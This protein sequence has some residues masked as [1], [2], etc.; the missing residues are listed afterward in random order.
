MQTRDEKIAQIETALRGR[1]FPLVPKVEIPGRENWLEWQHDTDRLSRALAAY[2][3]VG[4]CDLDD[5][6]AAAAIT[7]GSND[8]G[9]DALYFDRESNRLVFVQAKFKRN[10]AA[11]SQDENLKTING[12]RALQARR[13]NEFNAAFQDRLDTIEAGLDTVGV[14]ILLVLACLGDNHNVHV[15]ND[16][17]AL[18][19]EL[20]GLCR[21]TS[22]FIF[23]GDRS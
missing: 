23:S 1:F 4:L 20:E 9:I 14:Q 13:F 21:R 3:L 15:T 6:T 18:K 19:A 10:G 22:D 7:D 16:N 5:T 8:G 2:T 17:N 11:P 12:I